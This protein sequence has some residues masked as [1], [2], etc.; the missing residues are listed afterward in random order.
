MADDRDFIGYGPTR[1]TRNAGGARIAVNINVNFE[2]GGEH[3]IMEGDDASEGNLTDIGA[4][5]FAG[6]QKPL[7]RVGVRI[8]SRVGGWRCCGCS[9]ATGSRCA[10]WPSP[11][12]PNA[13]RN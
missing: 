12:Q 13:T 5:A 11:R 10:C 8:R 3:S 6:G 4:P 1:P 2:G 7:C 9:A